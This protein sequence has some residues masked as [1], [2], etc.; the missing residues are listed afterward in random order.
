M[1]SGARAGPRVLCDFSTIATATMSA[2]MMLPEMFAVTL[3]MNAGSSTVFVATIQPMS[4]RV[5][6]AA[7]QSATENKTSRKF[8][9]LSDAKI[10]SGAM[11]KN[12]HQNALDNQVMSPGNGVIASP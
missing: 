9:A 10:V 5:S 2:A 3:V 12:G 1:P 8:V 7:V 11:I 4:K 6:E